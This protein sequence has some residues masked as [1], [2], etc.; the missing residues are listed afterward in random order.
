MLDDSKY[1]RSPDPHHFPARFL[2]DY[3]RD[4]VEPSRLYLDNEYITFQQA[5]CLKQELEQA[6]KDSY[7]PP[8]HCEWEEG[9]DEALKNTHGST[10]PHLE[11]LLQRTGR[12]RPQKV[13]SLRSTG[14]E[15]LELF[16][17]NRDNQMIGNIPISKAMKEAYPGALYRHSGQSYVSEGW[18]RKGGT[19]KPFVVLTPAGA[20][21]T[22]TKPIMRRVVTV[23]T[24]SQNL[25]GYRHRPT[26][27][28]AA[29]GLRVN[30]TESV[31]GYEADDREGVRYYQNTS[32]QDPRKSRK[33]RD[34]PTT[35]L[36]LQIAE[37][38]AT[39]ATGDPQRDRTG[40]ARG[41]RERLAYRRSI[42]AADL[43]FQVDNVVVET[44]RGNY[45]SDNSIVV[46]DNIHGGLGLVHDLFDDLYWYASR[47]NRG[48]EQEGMGPSPESAEMFVQWVRD[49]ASD[50]SGKPPGAG[51][52]DWW[53]TVRPGSMVEV[54][55]ETMGQMCQ[56]EV[57]GKFWNAG[58]E[59]EVYTGGEIVVAAD[60]NLIPVASNFDWQLWQ[61]KTNRTKELGNGGDDGY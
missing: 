18:A 56:G 19:K 59:Y 36:H 3:Y 16:I 54:Y 20:R 17:G 34:F 61:P 41:F 44:P 33:Q 21:S 4:S 2:E 30:V 11:N 57:T 40:I 43:A 9:F 45:L 25:I 8:R 6:G 58:V 14:E 13:Y 55:S 26:A 29:S 24:G 53:R 28:G 52:K 46:Y 49:N 51:E 12:D 50:P 31:E 60:E 35:A 27:R 7:T 48:R 10:P 32:K 38:W 15:S 5:L 42:A 1:T 37:P 22:K 47:L 39:G 23:N